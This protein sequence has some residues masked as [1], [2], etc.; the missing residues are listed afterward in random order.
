MTD[1][2]TVTKEPSMPTVP[3]ELRRGVAEKAT[4]VHKELPLPDIK[5]GMSVTYMDS[6]DYLRAVPA[7]DEKLN[8]CES[9]EHKEFVLC[10]RLGMPLNLGKS[11][12]AATKASLQ[13][14][15]LDGVAGTLSLG[16]AK[17][18]KLFWQCLWFASRR[19]WPQQALR[20]LAGR[21]CFAATFRRPLM[22][23]LQTIFHGIIQA[24]SGPLDAVESPDSEHIVEEVLVFGA[25]LPLCYTNLR[26]SVADHITCSDASEW[27][28]GFC[29]AKQL[30]PATE[31]PEV[32]KSCG[33]CGKQDVSVQCQWCGHEFCSAQCLRIHLQ[34]SCVL[35][36][37]GM[38]CW[39]CHGGKLANDVAKHALSRG[40]PV[41][42]PLE[43]EQAH[44]D[45]FFTD[46]GR[47]KMK[48]IMS[49]AGIVGELW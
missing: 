31:I 23:V 18:A 15:W 39:A 36:A 34:G 8:E 47:G 32:S 5:E 11:L 10:L 2:D 35:R 7:L 46:E 41:L 17:S 40:I 28:G 33:S 13:G 42:G 38:S 9:S 6:Y 21:S 30:A 22:S 45:P 26:A 43:A 48:E 12:I 1:R 20:Q 49:H 25:L 4:E 44:I 14:G 19:Q 16:P 3:L 24:E 37:S 27:G 29:W